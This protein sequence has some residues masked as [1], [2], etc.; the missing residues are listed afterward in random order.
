MVC[1][2]AVARDE[3]DDAAR[4]LLV[5]VFLHGLV[6][7]RQAFRGKAQSFGRDGFRIFGVDADC[8]RGGQK[9]GQK[10]NGFKSGSGHRSPPFGRQ[11]EITYRTCHFVHKR[12]ESA[13]Q[14]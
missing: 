6:D 1:D 5:D 9:Q 8:N 14:G 3:D 12:K 2:R 11:T 13:V 4:S 7:A 10:K